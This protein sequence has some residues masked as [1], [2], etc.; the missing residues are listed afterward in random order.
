METITLM[1]AG[2][3]HG[4][5]AGKAVTILDL[6]KHR[7][8]FRD[9]AAFDVFVAMIVTPMTANSVTLVTKGDCAIATLYPATQAREAFQLKIA[10]RL[11]EDPELVKELKVLAEDESFVAHGNVEIS[12]NE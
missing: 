3:D 5:S 12:E 6:G 1:A 9:D 4:V 7:E 11:A 10:A 2:H 8:L